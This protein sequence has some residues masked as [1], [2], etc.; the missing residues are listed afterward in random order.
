MSLFTFIRICSNYIYTHNLRVYDLNSTRDNISQTL[1]CRDLARTAMRSNIKKKTHDSKNCQYFFL[2][3]RNQSVNIYIQLN[4]QIKEN[5]IMSSIKNV[6]NNL[7]Y[8]CVYK[9]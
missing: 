5:G 8:N 6:N 2:Y 1:Y 9:M 7:K 3:F 4:I